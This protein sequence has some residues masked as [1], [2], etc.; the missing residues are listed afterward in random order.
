M[1]KSPVEGRAPRQPGGRAGPSSSPLPAFFFLRF[2]LG[3][4]PALFD[5]LSRTPERQR[6]RRHVFCDAARRRDIGAA[7]NLY[8]RHQRRIAADEHAIFDHCLMFVHAVVIAGDRAR[9]D[10]YAFSDFRVAEIAE[11][12]RL[13]TLAQLDFLGLDKVSHASTLAHIT[14][15]AQMRVRSEDTSRADARIFHDRP[16]LH[17]DTVAD[18]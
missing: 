6:I 15:G 9:A 17:C 7:P 2:A 16:L 1:P 8:R 13:R 3:P 10:V 14:S 18:D 4:R 5:A 11:M 12:V